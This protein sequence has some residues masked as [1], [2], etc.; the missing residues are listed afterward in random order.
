MRK[1]LFYQPKPKEEGD[2]VPPWRNRS[3]D[4]WSEV[5]K[6]LVTNMHRIGRY[7]FMEDD[8]KG[9]KYIVPP[10]NTVLGRI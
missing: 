4:K 10:S 3:F 8:S 2:G 9:K 1:R 5:D 6:F 7:A